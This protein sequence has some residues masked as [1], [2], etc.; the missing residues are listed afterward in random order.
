MVLRKPY[1][2]IIKN[3]KKIHILLLVLSIYTLFKDNQVMTFVGSFID[4]NSYNPMFESIRDYISLFNYLILLCLMAITGVLI[5]VLH[6][7]KKPWKAYLLPFFDSGFL[8]F[9]LMSISGYFNHYGDESTLVT[10]RTLAQLLQIGSLLQYAVFILLFIRITGL[11]LKK[12]DFVHDQ[13]YLEIKEEDRE[14]FEVNVEIDKDSI[15]RFFKKQARHAKYLYQEH[16]LV[17]HCIF[18]ILLIGIGGY[19]YYYFGVLHKTYREGDVFSALSYQI[20]IQESYWTDKDYRGE[21]INP[22]KDYVALVIR[23]KNNGATR[24]ISAER[25]HLLNK[26]HLYQYTHKEDTAFKEI[27]IQSES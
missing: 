22:N 23:M 12:F 8:F 25:F 13:E 19:C 1:A 20:T 17:F 15:T 3:F 18:A 5:F 4:T 24:A 21:V 7:K 11:D 2:F 26:N 10:I 6:H 16:P 27:L 14:E 9:V